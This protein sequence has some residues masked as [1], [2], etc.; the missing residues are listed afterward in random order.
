MPPSKNILVEPDALLGELHPLA[1]QLGSTDGLVTLGSASASL[2]LGQVN[3]LPA[4]RDFMAAYQEQLLGPV[5]LPAILRAWQH[6]G[7]NELREFVAFDQL[8]AHNPHLRIF[9]SASRR[10]GQAQLKRLRPLRDQRFV[11]RY[12]QAVERG[13]AHGWHILVYGLTLSLYSLPVRQGLLNYARQTITGFLNAASRPLALSECAR[14]D[15]IEEFTA[16]L[17]LTI[18]TLLTDQQLAGGKALA[19]V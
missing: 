9:A 2:R 16:P 12:L 19:S 1:E 6:A 14:L 10:V 8:L 5:E 17:P 7:R 15:F 18:E 3:S 4:L 11:Q 13:E